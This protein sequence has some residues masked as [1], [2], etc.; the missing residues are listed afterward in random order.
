MVVINFTEEKRVRLATVLQCFNALSTLCSLF[1]I[2]GGL[3]IK[4]RVEDKVALIEDYGNIDGLCYTLMAFGVL[5]VG[6]NLFGM[7]VSSDSKSPETRSKGLVIYMAVTALFCLLVFCAGITTFAHK[8]HLQSAFDKG[9]TKAMNQYQH[10]GSLKIEVDILQTEY[11]CCGSEGPEDWFKMK[12]SD[13]RYLTSDV[14]FSCCNMRYNRPCIHHGLTGAAAGTHYN[15]KYE[16]AQK[17]IIYQTGCKEALMNY[18][19]GQVLET[20]GGT[21]MVIW[22]FQLAVTFGVRYLQTAIGSIDPSD[23]EGDSKGHIFAS[24]AK[25]DKDTEGGGGGKQQKSKKTKKFGKITGKFG[26]NKKKPVPPEPDYDQVPD[27]EPLEWTL[28][29][30]DSSF[31]NEPDAEQAPAAP[32]PPPP[33]P[34][35]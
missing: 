30:S 4:F 10:G 31:E 35:P 13:G 8:M 12:M 28:D 5:G 11:H 26:K 27:E 14:P 22:V 20:V 9:I 29:P 21:I 23:P 2:S 25:K 33:P 19:G 24:P 6:L 1:L 34:P 3:F 32:A 16:G 15:F 17:H 18:F 7:K